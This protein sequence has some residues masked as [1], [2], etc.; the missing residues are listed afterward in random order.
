MLDDLVHG[1]PT[2]L[3]V[4][5]E[6]GDDTADKCVLG[7]AER[8]AGGE[9]RCADRQGALVELQERIAIAG[10]LDN[11][12]VGALA[13]GN[14]AGVH[15]LVATGNEDVEGSSAGDNVVVGDDKAIFT[16]DKARPGA[17]GGDGARARFHEGALSDNLDGCQ[18][19]EGEA[20]GTLGLG[21]GGGIGGR[22]GFRDRGVRD[23]RLGGAGE[24]GCHFVC[25]LSEDGVEKFLLADAGG[26][27]FEVETHAEPLDLL[28]PLIGRQVE[29]LEDAVAEF[30]GD[31]IDGGLRLG[32]GRRSGRWDLGFGGCR[33]GGVATTG[34][35]E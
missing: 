22:G 21:G 34:C 3:T 18:L 24:S 31:A 14:D 5:I 26:R 33:G 13:G 19:D 8:V 15:W 23:F 10:K 30:L 25:T 4:G 9:Y 2:G 32:F 20:L 16:D 28:F 29:N 27:S 35:D 11:G 1:S 7:L 17:G 12:E 6:L